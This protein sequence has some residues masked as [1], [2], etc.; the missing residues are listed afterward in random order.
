MPLKVIWGSAEQYGPN[1]SKRVGDRSERYLRGATMIEVNWPH[2]KRVT[3]EFL[4]RFFFQDRLETGLLVTVIMV[5]YLVQIG[6]L[7]HGWDKELIQ[8]VFTTE[9]FPVP[10]P[11]LF[12]AIISHAFPPQLT[13]LFGNVALLWLFAGESEQHMRRA[14]V[15]GFFV[16]AALAAVLIGTAVSGDST[17]GASG[18]VLAFIGFYCVHM[19]LTSGRV[20]VRCTHVWW[21]DQY[22]VANV[23]GAHPSAHPD[24]TGAIYARA[25]GRISSGWSGRHRRPSYWVPMRDGI[26]YNPA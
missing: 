22:T 20:R 7:F 23:L 5:W 25:A 15:V 4:T 26:C 14:E 1:A 12:F 2:R 6:V 17:M 10:S 24:R 21:S 18:G 11:G 13:H 19:V 9:S 16:V 8:W 3:D